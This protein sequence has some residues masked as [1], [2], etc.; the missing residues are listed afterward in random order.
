MPAGWR[1]RALGGAHPQP[2]RQLCR[3]QPV[4]LRTRSPTH[5]SHPDTCSDEFDDGEVVGVVFFEAGGDGSEMFDLAEKPLDEI[6]ISIEERAESRDV[7]ASRH[8]LD[9]RTRPPR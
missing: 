4:R 9:V 6:A 8:R 1:R 5:K 2:G 3:D 7:L